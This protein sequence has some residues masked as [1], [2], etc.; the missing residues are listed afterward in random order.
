MPAFKGETTFG[1]GGKKRRTVGS[2][3]KQVRLDFRGGWKRPGA[4][5]NIGLRGGSHRNASSLILKKRKGRGIGGEVRVLRPGD[6][7]RISLEKP[8]DQETKARVTKR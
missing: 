6:Y 4:E 5:T 1:D 2:G 7:V 8:A 3:R